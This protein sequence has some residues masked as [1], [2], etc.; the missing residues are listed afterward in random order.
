MRTLVFF[1]FVCFISC[2]CFMTALGSH[3]PFLLYAVGFGAWGLFVWYCSGRLKK[4][5]EIRRREQAFLDFMRYQRR[6][7]R[8]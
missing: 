1:L 6:N 5:A 3:T 8:R 7:F 4:K 2:A